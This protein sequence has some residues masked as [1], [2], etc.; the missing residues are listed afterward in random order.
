MEGVPRARGAEGL[1][2]LEEISERYVMMP[3]DMALGYLG[4]PWRNTFLEVG[5]NEKG[6]LDIAGASLRG[7]SRRPL[8]LSA[9]QVCVVDLRPS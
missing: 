3:Y 9:S 7:Q 1:A 4:K 2:S 5:D 8:V 6:D